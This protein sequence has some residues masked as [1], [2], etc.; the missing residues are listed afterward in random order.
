MDEK[1]LKQ[2]LEDAA[3]ANGAAISE[4][5]KKEVGE[6]VKG[7]LTPDAL[8]A[9]LEAMGLKD[10]AISKLTKAV[11]TQGEEMRKIMAGNNPNAGKSIEELVHEKATEI[12][13]IAKSPGRTSFKIEL[14][15][16][17]KTEI[18]RASVGSSTQAMRLAGIGLLPYLGT[19]MSD[20]FPHVQVSPDSNGVIRYVDQ[21]TMTRNAASVAE[22]GVKPESVAAWTERSLNLQKIA[23]SIP[24]T[25]EAFNDVGFIAGEI[26]RLL[27]LNLQLKVDDLLYD[28]DGISPN[29][30]GV[31]TSA[32]A[33]NAATYAGT[34]FEANIYDLLATVRVEI[35]N[36]RQGKYNANVALMNPADIL[37]MKLSKGADGHYILPPFIAANGMQVDSMR[38]VESSQVT[39]DTLLVGDF[40]F[41]TIYDLEGVS[42]EMGFINDQ[43]VQ[44]TFTIL[45]EQRLGLLIRTVD[46][47]AFR[48]VTGITADLAT[49]GIV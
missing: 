21:S 17:N 18:T 8:Q 33:F 12:K 34:V 43:F 46:E 11:E 16:V 44:N 47:T 1:E 45:A 48:K 22:S 49:I 4:S 32:G 5:V 30:K 19:V 41:G 38:I 29:I 39:A 40:R 27:K 15:S 3:K 37:K 2:I 23:D 25:K 13:A 31:Y 6:A 26:D 42:V 35:M 9:K 28:G 10:D 14:P 24:V 20:L 36:N 7:L